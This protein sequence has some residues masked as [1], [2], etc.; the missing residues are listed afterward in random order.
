M[1]DEAQRKK[2]LD[3]FLSVFSQQQ[4]EFKF[5]AHDTNETFRPPLAGDGNEWQ[6]QAFQASPKTTGVGYVLWSR[7]RKP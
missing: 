6:F 4:R 2:A 3:D 5:T 7:I 1:E